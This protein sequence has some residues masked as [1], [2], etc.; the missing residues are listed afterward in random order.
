MRAVTI[1]ATV[2]HVLH[3]ATITIGATICMITKTGSAATF[4]TTEHCMTAGAVICFQFGICCSNCCRVARHGCTSLFAAIALAV[5]ELIER[6]NDTATP[7]CLQMQI[8][9]GSRNVTMTRQ[10]FNGVQI[11][12]CIEQVRSERMTKRMCIIALMPKPCLLHSLLQG[13]LYAP[14]MHTLAFGLP[15][16]QISDRTMLAKILSQ[17]VVSA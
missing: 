12:A 4:Y 15:F 16:K 10:F 1:A 7:M 17:S 14:A 13:M 2:I 8:D 5:I 3:S 11:G 9:H 6:I